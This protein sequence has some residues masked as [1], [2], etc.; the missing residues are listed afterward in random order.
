MRA[1]GTGAALHCCC[2]SSSSS[3]HR[4]SHVCSASL[5]LAVPC[6]CC[7]DV[8]L[9]LR[10]PRLLHKRALMTCGWSRPSPY[11]ISSTILRIC[12]SENDRKRHARQESG[13]A[14]AS[15]LHSSPL[16][17]QLLPHP[18]PT[19]ICQQRP[20]QAAC[21]RREPEKVRPQPTCSWLSPFVSACILL[22]ATSM[23]CFSSNPLNTTLKRPLPTCWRYRE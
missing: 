15:L 19:P 11:E 12:S 13:R 16:P 2:T 18:P 8:L 7:L 14:T 20:H 1:A 9:P 22:H 23:P 10:S 3:C 4:R 6:C 17:P 5:P 21:A